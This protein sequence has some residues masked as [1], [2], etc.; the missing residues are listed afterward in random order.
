MSS[1][2]VQPVVIRAGHPKDTITNS[3][4]LKKSSGPIILAGREYDGVGRDAASRRFHCLLLES[5]IT[6]LRFHFPC[7]DFVITGWII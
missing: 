3:E 6:I 7:G 2:D 4:K 5:S 1:L